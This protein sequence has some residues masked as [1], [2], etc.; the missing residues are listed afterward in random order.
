MP[1]F[2]IALVL[3]LAL[4]L[5]LNRHPSTFLFYALLPGTIVNLLITGGHGGSI[6]EQKIGLVAG[7]VVNF[8][9]YL[10]AALLLLRMRKSSN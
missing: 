8:L 5:L 7:V 10:M 2:I 9:V 3:V 4:T 6:T 1:A